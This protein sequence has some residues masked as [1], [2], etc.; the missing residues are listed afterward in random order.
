MM[1]KINKTILSTKH[2]Y[3]KELTEEHINDNY[4][5]WLKDKDIIDFFAS[6]F[7]D[8]TL[9]DLMNY[10]KSFHGNDSKYL[11]GVFTKNDHI[12]IGNTSVNAIN[13]LHE[14]CSW[15]YLI[16][17]KNYWGMNAGTDTIH[18]TMKFCFDVLNIRKT[19]ANVY[20][21]HVAARFNILKCGFKEE[22]NLAERFWH[23]NKLVDEIIYSMTREKWKK[24]IKL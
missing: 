6:T 2:F 11:F 10:Y 15:G 24:I 5:S 18:L 22:G 20:S 16:G 7:K 17:N 12:H 3:L 1:N 23:K 14:T 21:N 13:K 19:F 8:Y 4:L 9:E